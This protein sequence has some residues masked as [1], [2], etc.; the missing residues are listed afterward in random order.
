MAHSRLSR[1]VLAGVLVIAAG[2]AAS[3]EAQWQDAIKIGKSVATRPKFTDE[4]EG[5][6]AQAQAKKFDAEHKMWPEPLLEAY[7]TGIVQ[8]LVAVA[9]PVRFRTAC[10]WS[11]IRP[12][13][14]SRSAA[15]CCTSTPA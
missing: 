10:A 9:S 12:S 15:G 11:A 2:R 13:T 3:V 4:D 7:V 5:R 8:K 1:F 6:M 14:R